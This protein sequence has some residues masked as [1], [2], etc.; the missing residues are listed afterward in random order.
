M[1]S[2]G[3]F[4]YRLFEI[5]NSCKGQ[6]VLPISN[7]RSQEYLLYVLIILGFRRI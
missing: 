6:A 4:C 7:F 3:R 2:C 5:K 1:K